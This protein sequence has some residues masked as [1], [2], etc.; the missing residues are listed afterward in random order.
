[1]SDLNTINYQPL[2]NMKH[3]GSIVLKASLKTPEGILLPLILPATLL[4]S[5]LLKSAYP[6]IIGIFA[7][8]AFITSKAQAYKNNL[9]T[10]FALANSWTLSAALTDQDIP[11]SLV[12][13]HSQK[14]STAVDANVSSIYFGAFTYQCTTGSGR[15]QQLHQFTVA[16]VTLPKVLPHIQ[17]LSKKAKADVKRDLANAQNLQLEGDFDKY[18]SLQ[19]ESG[20]QIDTL[21]VLTPEIM[22]TLIS[23]NNTEDIEILNNQLYF[24]SR[25]D[26]RDAQN[27]SLLIKSVVELSQQIIQNINLTTPH[28]APA[29]NPTT[30]QTPAPTET[31]TATNI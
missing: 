15:Y 24:I 27:V 30:T 4:L 5:I 12:F 1:M 8:G 18:F 2:T 29:P 28:A 16:N 19:I 21:S 31:P 13:G 20:Q 22:Q 14:F 17:L 7:Y 9:W 3:A 23:Y 11:P 25:G 6:L 10:N 26:N